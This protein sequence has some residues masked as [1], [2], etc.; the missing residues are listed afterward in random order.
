MKLSSFCMIVNKICNHT[1]FKDISQRIQNPIEKQLAVVLY[2]LRSK[3]TIWDICLKIGKAEGTKVHQVFKEMCGF[4][5]V[6]GVLDRPH[7]NLFEAPSMHK[8]LFY[9]YDI[10]Q[11]SQQEKKVKLFSI[12]PKFTTQNSFI[13]I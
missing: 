5:N 3:A 9:F 11:N 7:M 13:R 8:T 12:F 2:K 6:I 4:P 10:Y 1:V